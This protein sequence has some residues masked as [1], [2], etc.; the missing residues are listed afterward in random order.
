[1]LGEKGKGGGGVAEKEDGVRLGLLY[2]RTLLVT[3]F[4][5]M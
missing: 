1:M 4:I 3:Y 2:S 5:Y